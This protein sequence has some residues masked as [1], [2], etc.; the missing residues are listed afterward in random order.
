MVFYE[1]VYAGDVLDDLNNGLKYGVESSDGEYM[2]WFS[3][4]K[5]LEANSKKNGLKIRNRKMFLAY[6]IKNKY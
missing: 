6:I 5:K 1:Y 2:E 3:S 4:I